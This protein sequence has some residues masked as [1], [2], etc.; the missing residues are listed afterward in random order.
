MVRYL[1]FN[2]KNR[3]MKNF[4]NIK[5]LK[6]ETGQGQIPLLA[7]IAIYSVSMVTSLPGLA[8]SP[9]LGDLESVFKD[10]SEFKIQLLES[11]PSFIIIPFVLLAGQLSVSVNKRKLL[12]VGLSL[13]VASSLLY[14][15]TKSMNMLLV[16]S[17]TLGIGSG[18]VIPFSTG[19]IA[20]YFSGERRTFQLGVV[21][22]VANLSLVLATLL[23][24]FLAGIGWR[25]AFGV[26]CLSVISLVFSF[27]LDKKNRVSAPSV[28]VTTAPP[29]KFK[30]PYDIMTRYLWVTVI[31]LIVPF[32]LSILIDRL[33]VGSSG[34]SGTIISLFFL[35]IML[36]GFFITRIR[37]RLKGHIDKTAAMIMLVGA[38]TLL[39]PANMPTVSIGTVLIGLGYG[40]IQPLIYDRT[41]ERFPG[42]HATLGLSVVMSMNYLAIIMFPLFIKIVGFAT[43]HIFKESVYP[44]FIFAA[45]LAA[46]YAWHTVK[47]EKKRD[48]LVE[49]SSSVEESKNVKE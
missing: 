40:V 9:I 33:Q 2:V 17:V 37:R 15:T 4:T 46:V 19:L 41:A 49:E 16:Y 38:L 1:S 10:A 44:P 42:R 27:F 23:A 21:S 28:A 36:P 29:K 45:L 32:N 22:A 43:P 47:E 25:W 24:G 7:L 18:I 26:Y 5:N 11:L 39:I 3:A 35:A 8:I 30:M 6:I 48:A 13:F 14:F 20:D 31:A 34:F 12:I